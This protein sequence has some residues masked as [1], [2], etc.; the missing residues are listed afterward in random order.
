MAELTKDVV[1]SMREDGDPG[2]TVTLKIRFSDFE[3]HTRSMAPGDW[4]I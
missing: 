3:T 1:K 4:W 2:R